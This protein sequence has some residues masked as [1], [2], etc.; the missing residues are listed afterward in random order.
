M[1]KLGSMTHGTCSFG[2]AHQQ[3]ARPIP[4]VDQGRSLR[5]QTG[6]VLI[7]SGSFGEI[8]PGRIREIADY[9]ESDVVNTYLVWL[10]YELFRGRLSDAE[11]S[12][13]RGEPR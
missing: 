9:C 4:A 10:R 8:L 3:A 2:G 6:F 5:I 12:G 1:R 13:E 11:F 7:A